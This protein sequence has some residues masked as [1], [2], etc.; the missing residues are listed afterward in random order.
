MLA[1]DI[2]DEGGAILLAKAVGHKW[3]DYAQRRLAGRRHSVDTS[4]V[5]GTGEGE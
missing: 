1:A 4:E 2:Q 3:A 5:S